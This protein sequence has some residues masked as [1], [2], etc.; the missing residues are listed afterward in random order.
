[1]ETAVE[2]LLTKGTATEKA[3]NSPLGAKDAGIVAKQF[4]YFR[5]CIRQFPLHKFYNIEQDY[6]MR[7][8]I[9]VS[10]QGNQVLLTLKRKPPAD[11]LLKALES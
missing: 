1:V 6:D 5:W 8:R 4:R 7:T 2:E 10:T 3:L 11:P 9:H